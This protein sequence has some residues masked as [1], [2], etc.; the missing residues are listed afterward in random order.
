MLRGVLKYLHFS[1]LNPQALTCRIHGG[2]AGNR[3]FKVSVSVSE[4]DEQGDW[5]GVFALRRICTGRPSVPLL[6]PMVR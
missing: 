3:V 4:P 2:S 6:C 5:C 1:G